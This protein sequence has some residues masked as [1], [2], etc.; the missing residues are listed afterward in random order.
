MSGIGEEEEDRHKESC[1]EEKAF[2]LFLGQLSF[3]RMNITSTLS[4]YIL[5]QILVSCFCQYFPF[6]CFSPMHSSGTFLITG[7]FS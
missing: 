5:H 7:F 1:M 6:P 4:H 3:Y 2:F